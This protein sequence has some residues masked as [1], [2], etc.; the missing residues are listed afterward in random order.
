MLSMLNLGDEGLEGALSQ[1]GTGA[2]FLQL[3]HHDILPTNSCVHVGP[4]V[5]EAFGFCSYARVKRERERNIS[6][7]RWEPLKL[8]RKSKPSG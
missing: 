6:V 4:A 5:G 2:P 7:P 3:P 1:P 8:N